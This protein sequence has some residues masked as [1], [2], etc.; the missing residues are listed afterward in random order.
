MRFS[1]YKSKYNSIGPA[2]G[3]NS[4]EK[5]FLKSSQQS[6]IDEDS[7]V[8]LLIYEIR[9]ICCNFL[10]KIPL[11]KNY[12]VARNHALLCLEIK[13]VNHPRYVKP[14]L[15]ECLKCIDVLLIVYIND[16]LS[17]N[18]KFYDRKLK[19]TDVYKH[20]AYSKNE[21]LKQIGNKLNVVYQE[22]NFLEH[23][24][25]VD[26]KGKRQIKKI[27]NSRIM[28]KYKFVREYIQESLDILVPLYR[29]AFP[30]A[31]IDENSK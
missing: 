19:E 8:E 5:G 6:N 4:V 23:R 31:C 30:T 3:V 22:R 12:E 24:Q 25:I 27:S 13:T 14:W 1:D 17:E 16:V 21:K 11:G 2:S 10:F 18:V 29:K 26:D 15:S 9:S 20:L 28:K 7:A